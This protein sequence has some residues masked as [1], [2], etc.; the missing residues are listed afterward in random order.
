MNFLKFFLYKIFVKFHRE[1]NAMKKILRIF[2]HFIQNIHHISFL[3]PEYFQ[4][5]NFGNW[6]TIFVRERL[7]S[8]ENSQNLRNQLLKIR[9]KNITNPDSQRE[10]R[11]VLQKSPFLLIPIKKLFR[12]FLK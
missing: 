3:F 9:L 4:L 7:C 2:F 8:F 1:K 12:K 5:I 6:K 10:W 11:Q